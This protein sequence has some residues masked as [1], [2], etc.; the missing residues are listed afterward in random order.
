[1]SEKLYALLLRLYPA[2]FRRVY[3]EEAMQLLRDRLRDEP[4]LFARLR[5]WLDL[6]A[7]LAFSLPRE[8]RAMRSGMEAAAAHRPSAGMPCFEVLERQPPRAAAV[9]IAATL[10][11]GGTV[12]F[13]LLLNYAG[14]PPA[15][16]LSRMVRRAHAQRAEG[17]T[18][19]PTAAEL[20]AS[21]MPFAAAAE[22]GYTAAPAPG[23][24]M[25]PPESP[26]PRQAAAPT[27]IEVMRGDSIDAAERHRVI[28][29]A[30]KDLRAF[31]FDPKVAEKTADALLA[32]EKNG[33]DN[34]AS[35][36]G[37]FAALL[38]RQMRDASQDMHL[39]VEYSSNPLPAQAVAPTPEDMARYRQAMQQQNCSIE[40]VA[41]LEHD[42]G[43]LKLDSFPDASIC[44]EQI[45]AAVTALNHS[46]A[47]IIDL[48]E[49]HGGFPET[50]A[51][52]AAPL[53]DRP[54]AWY[55]PR[56]A[57]PDFTSSPVPGSLLADKPVYILT[58]ASTWS[59]AEQF[60][61]N[62]K[63]LHRATLVGDTTR[64]G[65]HAGAFHRIDHH[66]GMGIP[67]IRIVNPYGGADWAGVGVTP[68]VKVKAADAL[69]TAE[70]LA[71]S[72][73]AVMPR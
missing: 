49:N 60:S 5:L 7:D 62:L 37:A 11:L 20:S 41:I 72:R 68:D 4:G 73:L 66:F 22:S 40:K 17:P 23:T 36:G 28:E 61:Y 57:Q 38:T 56:Q 14:I 71:A 45:T 10:S 51:L 53:F 31:Y 54:R 24:P 27:T 26:N 43:Y 58:S 8:H 1:M 32:Q 33:N 19:A 12:A 55:N 2:D 13:F 44:G 50:V 47:L 69:T 70:K 18:P 9:M 59:G 65:A 16:S 30:A 21:G 15:S 25:P 48:R 29:A 67:E 3:G 34:A 35:S 63:M 6:V 46:D 52:V 64:G 42:I 39:V